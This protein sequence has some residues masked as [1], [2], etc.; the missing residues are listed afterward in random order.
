MPKNVGE[1]PVVR[2]KMVVVRV[3]PHCS[4]DTSGPQYEQY[5]QQKLMLHMPFREC[6]QLKA[7]R[8]TFAEAFAGYL[9]SGSI[10]PSLED[11]LYRLQQQQEQQDPGE[12]DSDSEELSDE[13]GQHN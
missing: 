3:R 12:S 7:G 13:P 5:C 4:P 2:K 10:P 1:E 8:D 11:D 9:Q 6:Q